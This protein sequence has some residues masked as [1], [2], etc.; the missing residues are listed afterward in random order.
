MALTPA[1]I[2]GL[3]SG[4][5]NIIDTGVNAVL[6]GAQNKKNR[7]F[8]EKMYNRQR[9]DALSDWNMQNAYN[10]PSAQM[11]RLKNAKLNPNLIYG[12]GTQ[13]SGLSSPVRSSSAST[14]QGQAPQI[15]LGSGLSSYIDTQIKLQQKNVM[16]SVIELNQERKRQIIADTVMKG[17]NTGLI[18]TKNAAESFKLGLAQSLKDITLES[19]DWRL[20]GQ[21]ADVTETYTNIGL[22]EA[23]RI[24]TTDENGRRERLTDANINQKLVSMALMQAQTELAKANKDLTEDRSRMIKTQVL[25]ALKTGE[26][27]KLKNDLLQ[28]ELDYQ[29]IERTQS[30][31]KTIIGGMKK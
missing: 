21:K 3:I 7:K 2:S 18:N 14:P 23:Q 13:A 20:R 25:N 12:T 17:A 16:D 24:L 27:L 19:A 1:Q 22:K 30:W 10:A 9:A 28:S 6:Q 31:L 15:S 5:S 11:E 4:G 8:A 29:T 26:G